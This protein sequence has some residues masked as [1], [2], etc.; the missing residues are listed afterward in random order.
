MVH[1]KSIDILKIAQLN[2]EECLATYESERKSANN[3]I[4]SIEKSKDQN[5]VRYIMIG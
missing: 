2:N 3:L 4:D 1:K 5:L